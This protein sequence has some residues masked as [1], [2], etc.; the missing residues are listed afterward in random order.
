M[1]GTA[2][3]IV[4]RNLINNAITVIIIGAIAALF[5]RKKEKI[6]EVF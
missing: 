4:F 2:N 5:I 6:S 3:S 1:S